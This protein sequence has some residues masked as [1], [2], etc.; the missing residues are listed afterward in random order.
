MA[1]EAVLE[2]Y[3]AMLSDARSPMTSR[4]LADAALGLFVMLETGSD[5]LGEDA[6]PRADDICVLLA[7]LLRRLAGSVEAVADFD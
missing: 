7:E 6:R 1:A 3:E 4:Q 5:S 2:K